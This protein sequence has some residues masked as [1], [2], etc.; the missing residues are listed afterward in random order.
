MG[1]VQTQDLPNSGF[2]ILHNL[3]PK[4]CTSSTIT[5]ELKVLSAKRTENVYNSI[6]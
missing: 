6:N 1:N 2:A 4:E 3:H 5:D